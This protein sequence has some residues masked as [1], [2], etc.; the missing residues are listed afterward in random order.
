MESSKVTSPVLCLIWMIDFYNVTFSYIW[1]V[2]H[3]QHEFLLW[4]QPKAEVLVFLTMQWVVA[5]GGVFCFV[6]LCFT[7]TNGTSCLPPPVFPHCYWLINFQKIN[8]GWTWS[9]V[10]LWVDLEKHLN[11]REAAVWCSQRTAHQNAQVRIEGRTPPV[12]TRKWK[13]AS[14]FVQKEK[15]IIQQCFNGCGFI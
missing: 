4:K 2:F 11:Q 8:K 14:A 5:C 15:T 1:K 3:I 6:L 7:Y 9:C 13:L 12:S 10:L